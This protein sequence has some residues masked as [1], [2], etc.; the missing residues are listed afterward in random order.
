MNNLELPAL[1][2]DSPR[3]FHLAMVT[4]EPLVSTAL[5][6]LAES[7]LDSQFATEATELLVTTAELFLKSCQSAME[8]TDPQMLIAEVLFS[9][10]LLTGNPEISSESATVLTLN[11]DASTHLR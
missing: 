3:S 10:R 1:L 7:N 6:L 4:T 8:Q 9:P 5:Q 2:P 11:M